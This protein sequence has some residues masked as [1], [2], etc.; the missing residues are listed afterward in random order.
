MLQWPDSVSQAFW[1][2]TVQHFRNF[3]DNYG[4]GIQPYYCDYALDS[5]RIAGKAALEKAHVKL[6][7]ISFAELHDSYSICGQD[8]DG[9]NE[10]GAR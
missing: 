1:S 9:E 6:E 4:S 5:A 2:I 10:N 3:L 8:D 7:D